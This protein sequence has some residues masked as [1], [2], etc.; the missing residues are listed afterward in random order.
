MAE[1][2]A[3]LVKELR[4]RT[5]AGMMDCKKAL[6][7]AN[8]NLDAAIDVLRKK[9]L[10]NISKRAGKVAAE[11]TVQTYIH[12]DGKIGVMIELNCETDF[13]GRGEE[14][15]ALAH[16]ISMH[17]AWANPRFLDAESV[18]E[19]VKQ[20]EAEIHR[21]QIKPEQAAMADKIIEG[22]MKKFYEENCLV[23]QFD[24]RD[25]AA[26]KRIG[27]LM[28]DLSAKVGEK[29]SLR[30][31]VRFELGEGIEKEAVDFAK[32]VQE[33]MHA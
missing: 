29:V 22:K 21:S 23:E 17:I 5:S 18:P 32:E 30:R 4:D 3:K 9:G 33:A 27:D 13:V 10:K 31:F 25:P 24:V 28:N 14:F 6:E 19:S 11:G 1:V 8:G 7:E 2:S 12:G 16:A 20:Q 15:K 26:K